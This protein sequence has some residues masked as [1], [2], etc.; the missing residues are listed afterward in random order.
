[1]YKLP[2]EV[3]Q[4]N[5]ALLGLCFGQLES[6]DVLSLAPDNKKE[7]AYLVF[8]RPRDESTSIVKAL[9]TLLPFWPFVRRRERKWFRW[10][11][12]KQCAFCGCSHS[13]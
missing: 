6:E 2:I 1:I 13:F 11:C 10:L 3:A 8:F 12:R 9:K 5:A 7:S 4:E